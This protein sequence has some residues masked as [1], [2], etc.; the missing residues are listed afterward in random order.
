MNIEIFNLV[1]FNSTQA[2]IKAEKELTSAK[3]NVRIIPVPREITADCGISL[4]VNT[5]DLNVV[6]KVLADKNIEVSGYYYIKK[7]GLKKEVYEC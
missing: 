5:E 3:I 2:A 7:K 4:K 6:R 1:A